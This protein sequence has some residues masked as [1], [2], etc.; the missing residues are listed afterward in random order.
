MTDMN[1][2]PEFKSALVEAGLSE[3]RVEGM[4]RYLGAAGWTRKLSRGRRRKNGGDDW[5]AIHY[6]ATVLGFGAI[7]PIDAPN[8]VTLLGELMHTAST[9]HTVVRDDQGQGI[10]IQQVPDRVIDEN[11]HVSLGM[12]ILHLAKMPDAERQERR[13]AARGLFIRLDLGRLGASVPFQYEDGSWG[14]DQFGPPK[15]NA[16]MTLCE[17]RLSWGFEVKLEIEIIFIA[18]D[19]LAETLAKRSGGT[20]PSEEELLAGGE[21]SDGAAT[22]NNDAPDLAGPE[23]SDGDRGT[24]QPH[25]SP[26]TAAQSD[27]AEDREP[28]IFVQQRNPV[29]GWALA[30]SSTS[31]TPLT[32]IPATCPSSMA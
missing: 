6:A 9:L 2:A 3:P 10:A 15:R 27:S 4:F 24:T 7:N 22:T 1:G 29:S 23:A 16:L 13:K 14:L 30:R 21:T 31:S 8:A 12:Q 20:E 17:P 18:A 5:D 28:G 26:D 32:R 19:L 11:L 25:R